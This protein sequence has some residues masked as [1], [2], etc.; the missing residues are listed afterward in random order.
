VS[1]GEDRFG[2]LG[3]AAADGRSAGE[4]L[5]ERDRL[6]PEPAPPPPRPPRP[7]SRYA[8][9][10]GIVMLMGIG[11]LLFTTALPNT[12]RGLRG[13]ERGTR[14]R[15][16]AAP[17]ATGDL[18]GGAN[19][20]QRRG[21]PK[22]AGPVPACDVVSL[23]VLNVCELWRRPLVLT[24]VFDRG[25]DC[26][27]QV[28]RVERMRRSVPGVSFAAVYFSRKP[29]DEVRLIVERRGWREPVGL[30]RDGAVVNLYRVGGCPTTV[31]A[32]RG[33]RV[34]HTLLGNLTEAQLRSNARELLR[35]Q[36]AIDRRPGSG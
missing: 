18:T 33:G 27:P 1:E 7:T 17:L 15:A 29:R 9:L 31:F 32:L 34:L 20:C 2:D 8:W 6:E 13:P 25:A 36:A 16:F 28:D 19:V 3:G 5:E 12:G 22:D 35:R 24:F 21:C 11:V 10:V 23:Q 30:D 26:F 14:L 4:R